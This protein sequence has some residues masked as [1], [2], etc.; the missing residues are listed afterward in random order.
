MAAHAIP[1]IDV[2][3][4]NDLGSRP[5]RRLRDQGRLPVVIYGHQQEQMHGSVDY[6]QI[7]DAIRSGSHVVEVKCN[8]KAESCLVKD[9]QWNY[10]GNKVIHVD[11][12]RV[13]LSEKV[14]LAVPIE[15][16]GNAPGLKE[17]GALLEHPVAELSISCR[18][19]QIPDVI[20]LDVSAMNVGDMIHAGEI[21]LPEG[22]ELDDDPEL[23]VAHIHVAK[24]KEEEV[25]EVT[26]E[27]GEP[28]VIGKGGE[29]SDEAES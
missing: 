18:A 4:R 25:E 27:E 3:P 12:A 24:I 5:T 20:Q 19:D 10:L 21:K 2:E 13:D 16:V 22:V 29:E 6:R 23:L 15:I 9:L 14:T 8:G 17:A 11:L 28:E 7:V 1:T 26:E